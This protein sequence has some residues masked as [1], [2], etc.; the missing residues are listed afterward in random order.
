MTDESVGYRKP[1]KSTQFKAGLSGNPKGRPKRKPVV[2][3]EVVGHVLSAPIEYREKGR[4][5]TATRYELSLKM[6]VERAVK[7]SL[8]AA[9]L[10]L[11]VRAHA[12]R[13]GD[14]G[15]ERLQISDWLP[16]YPGQTAEQKTQEFAAT[17]DASPLQWWQSDE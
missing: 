5:R 17:G 14:A 8:A 4:V 16:D 9:D 1:P 11:K 3:A 7:G 6:L 13:Y 2:L 15:V 12:L 10:I